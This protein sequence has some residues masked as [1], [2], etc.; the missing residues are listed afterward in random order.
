MLGDAAILLTIGL[1]AVLIAAGGAWWIAA[2]AVAILILLPATLIG[3]RRNFHDAMRFRKFL[4]SVRQ[5]A[6]RR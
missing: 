4:D 2:V 5:P 3:L 1:I 6:H